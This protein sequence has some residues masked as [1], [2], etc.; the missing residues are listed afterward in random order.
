[1]QVLEGCQFI[2]YENE[3]E[4]KERTRL[5]LD[6]AGRF[7]KNGDTSDSFTCLIETLNSLMP[8]DYERLTGLTVNGLSSWLKEPDKTGSDP[9]I[10]V[11]GFLLKAEQSLP[12]D[13]FSRFISH[14]ISNQTTVDDNTKELISSAIS[15]GWYQT[16]DSKPQSIL[17]PCLLTSLEIN[18][19]LHYHLSR[20]TL[21]AQ[22]FEIICPSSKH[23]I[24]KTLMIVLFTL[25]HYVLQLRGA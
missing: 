1:M 6:L 22:D 24:V 5:L 21:T 14:L 16:T 15:A 12:C 20:N 23:T 17:L 3:E 2:N 25:Q 4:E 7:L 9:V 18:L 19:I 10:K 11:I 8:E 13:L